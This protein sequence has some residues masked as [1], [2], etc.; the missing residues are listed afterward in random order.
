MIRID[1]QYYNDVQDG[2][3]ERKFQKK[4]KKKSEKANI[5]KAVCTKATRESLNYETQ[6]SASRK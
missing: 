4:K 2:R 5:W 3:A 1:V 6:F